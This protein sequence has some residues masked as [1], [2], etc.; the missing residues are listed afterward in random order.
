MHWDLITILEFELRG[1]LAEPG[2]EEAGVVHVADEDAADD[3]ADGEDVGDGVG[4]DELVGHALLSAHHH[5]VEALHGD[6]RSPELV[7]R[8]ERILHL[9]DAPI[10]RKHFH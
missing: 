9:V 4:H 8:L 1:L 2:D 7:D 3:V 10:R 5:G 6:R